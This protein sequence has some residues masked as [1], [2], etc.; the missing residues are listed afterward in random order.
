[1]KSA[2]RGARDTGGL[3]GMATSAS[4]DGIMEG[5][6]RCTPANDFQSNCLG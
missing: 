5:I 3:E 4:L 6:C 2:D 1:M